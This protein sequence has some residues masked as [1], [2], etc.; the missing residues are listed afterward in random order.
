M[1]AIFLKGLE[2]NGIQSAKGGSN[3]ERI[4][5]ALFILSLGASF[6]GACAKLPPHPV[7]PEQAS[8]PPVQTREPST[9][10]APRN[11]LTEEVLYKFLLAEIAG[12]R[13]KL[14]LSVETYL[15]LAR[16]IPDPRVAERATQIAVFAKKD[17]EALEAA[18]LWTKYA[19]EDLDARQA[20]AAMHIRQGQSEEALHQLE[21]VMSS[22]KGDAKQK[23]RM[24]AGFLSR[25]E[26]RASALAVM[27]RLVAERQNDADAMFAY[28]LLAVR[29][30]R[31]DKALQAMERVIELNPDDNQA[32]LAYISVL[33]KQGDADNALKWVDKRLKQQPEQ[34]ELRMVYA[35][36]LAEEK[37]FDEA[38]VQFKLLEEA[39]RD[40]PDV[41]YALGWLGIQT[42]ELAESEAYFTTL[43]ESGQRV[44]EA[45]YYLGHIAESKNEYDNALKWYRA[46]GSGELHF[47]AQIRVALVLV[48]QDKA[49]EAM[50]HLRAVE[51]RD[52][53]QTRRLVLAQ[54]E[55]L[56]TQEQ[57]TEAM[58]V[59]DQALKAEHDAD[60]LYSRAMLAEK[61][62]KLDLLE[63]DLRQ[64]LDR[65][66]DNVQA[67]NALGYTLADRT[68]RYQEA[69][70]LIKRALQLRPND[71]YILDSMGWVLY[72]MGKIEEALAY[73][74]RAK[75][76]RDDPEIAAHLGEVLWVKGDRKEAK[77]VWEDA[78]KNNPEDKKLRE[79][80]NRLAP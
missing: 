54:A 45:S 8:T 33:Q 35:R 21:Y 60:L 76:L 46:I 52:S 43:V 3:T 34:F 70:S 16:S 23:L 9:Q 11:E 17:T 78:L 61:M 20:L 30:E 68:D 62:G 55:I 4:P 59:Y 27:E 63:S 38:R 41:Q 53:E 24:I 80:I 36:L 50:R 31:Y 12:Q 75:V 7:P 26:D 32:I 25:E 49:K 48:Q 15:E 67:L 72:R 28:A 74:R 37:R 58:R 77:N 51:A 65:E 14:E 10:A 6:L 79:V 13:G 66:P 56:T 71:F 5:I 44:D 69:Y 73:L 47:D 40:N 19:S 57:Y 29:A 42:N 1:S 2:S 39:Q 64:I 22:N 18:K